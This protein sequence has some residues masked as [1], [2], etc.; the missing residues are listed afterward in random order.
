V[1]GLI[2]MALVVGTSSG[3]YLVACRLLRLQRKELLVGLRAGLQWIGLA[4]VFFGA[5]LLVGFAALLTLRLVTSWFVSLYAVA[6]VSIAAF[7]CLQAAVF[8]G[9]LARRQPRASVAGR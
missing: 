6:D 8:H 5:N 1:D 7:S 4:A 9:W 2:V 3:A